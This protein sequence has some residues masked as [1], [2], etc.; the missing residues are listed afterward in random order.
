[1]QWQDLVFTTGQIIFSI[2]LIPSILSK[3]KPALSSSLITSLFLFVYALVYTTMSLW[4]ASI[5]TA[6]TASL[7]F[8]LAAQ[9]YLTAKKHSGG[10]A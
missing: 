5:T 6:V 4:F 7:W 9:K 8:V 1:M 10:I 2:A 3:N